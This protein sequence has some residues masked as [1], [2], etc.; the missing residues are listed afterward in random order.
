MVRMEDEMKRGPDRLV[1]ARTYVAIGG[2]VLVGMAIASGNVQFAVP[3]IL[4]Y[5]AWMFVRDAIGRRTTR[6][7]W[8]RS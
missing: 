5:I 1:R 4:G 3:V 2:V 6:K 8:T 7:G